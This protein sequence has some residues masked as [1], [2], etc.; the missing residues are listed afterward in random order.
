MGLY[1]RQEPKERETEESKKKRRRRDR[2]IER[3]RARLV[4]FV[5]QV[6]WRCLGTK[7]CRRDVGTITGK[8]AKNC[9]WGRL[10]I[11]E[12]E[13]LEQLATITVFQQDIDSANKGDTTTL[14]ILIAH[15]PQNHVHTLKKH[16]WQQEML[17]NES[18]AVSFLKG[19]QANGW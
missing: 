9:A 14:K 10:G 18:C 8:C 6:C 7:H 2:W 12:N 16:I 5:V 1:G 11:S 19:P 17:K 3:E 13:S 4:V 15:T